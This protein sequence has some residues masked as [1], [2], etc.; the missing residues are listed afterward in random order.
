MSRL[1]NGVI[2]TG[3]PSIDT[4][5][6][7]GVEV[8][9]RIAPAGLV[10]AAGAAASGA[11]GLSP[12]GFSS[13][14]LPSADFGSVG[15]SAG[16]AAASVAAARADAPSSCDL[17]REPWRDEG[18]SSPPGFSAG[19]SA[20]GFSAGGAAATA[21]A[22]AA[23]AGI[24]GSA[25]GAGGGLGAAAGGASGAIV[26][27][28]DRDGV[29]RHAEPGRSF[30]MTA[31]AAPRMTINA[32]TTPVPRRPVERRVG[33]GRR[34]KPPAHV[35]RRGA[36]HGC[37]LRRRRRCLRR[38]RLVHWP[39]S[40]HRLGT[41][42]GRGR[43]GAASPA[44]GFGGRA[45]R[46]GDA[47]RI[48][49]DVLGL[50][51]EAR[52]RRHLWHGRRSGRLF[53]NRQRLV[54][55]GRGRRLEQ[56]RRHGHRARAGLSRAGERPLG[57]RRARCRGGPGPQKGRLG[58]RGASCPRRTLS[59]CCGCAS[60][61]TRGGRAGG[62]VPT[63]DRSS[64]AAPGRWIDGAP[65]SRCP[66]AP[67]PRRPLPARA[68]SARIR[69]RVG[70]VSSLT[71]SNRTAMPGGTVGRA[72]IA[73]AD[74]DDGAFTGQ[75]RHP[76]LQL[77]LQPELRPHGQRFA[78]ADE[79]PTA[80]DVRRVPLDELL[81]GGAAELDAEVGRSACCSLGVVSLM[82]LPLAPPTL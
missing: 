16:G 20:T 13:V 58:R 57:R 27:A 44:A 10:S 34:A 61:D 67:A 42:F 18:R 6:P 52:H 21:G 37:L 43:A 40:P 63:R 55:V 50:G 56:R 62:R 64:R 2:P 28:D 59:S 4:S 19:F 74:P 32:T 69:S 39:G 14:G 24:T 49:R 75:Q 8:I 76:V 23:G 33:A 81:E 47:R 68:F 48:V 12:A 31:P 41:R 5:A 11:A 73:L 70:C 51:D 15:F 1:V 35:G 25:G 38:R 3:L 53:Q 45:G 71:L 79:D 7:A 22:G 26:A 9:F 72:G 54:D 65:P 17:C 80:A 46:V 30:Q 82:L 77:Q 29:R 78:R 36:G 66:A 60:V